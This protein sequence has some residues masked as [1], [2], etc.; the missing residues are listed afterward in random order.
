MSKLC[1]LEI[2]RF[3]DQS[4]ERHTYAFL[5]LN[6]C[7]CIKGEVGVEGMDHSDKGTMNTSTP[8]LT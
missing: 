8:T 7:Q 1:A 2:C 6:F 4:T 3:E 5:Q